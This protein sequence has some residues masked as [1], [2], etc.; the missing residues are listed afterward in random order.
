MTDVHSC[1]CRVT[2]GEPIA[3]C[4]THGAAKELL[5]VCKS[6]DAFQRL[7]EKRTMQPGYMPGND[8]YSDLQMEIV[9]AARAAIGKVEGKS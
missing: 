9:G 2:E 8:Y 6:L 4:P 7:Y 1:G 5:A 3:Y